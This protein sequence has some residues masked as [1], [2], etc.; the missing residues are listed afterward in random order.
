MKITIYIYINNYY[1]YKKIK[2][3]K[4]H[5]HDLLQSLSIS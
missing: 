5:K 3:S 4:D 2:A 1:I